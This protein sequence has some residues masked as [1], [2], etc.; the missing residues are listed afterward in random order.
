MHATIW[1]ASRRSPVA[2]MIGNQIIVTTGDPGNV[3]AT[4]TTWIGTVQGLPPVT[5]P[6]PGSWSGLSPLPVALG[7]VAGGVIGN[8]L[9]LV[10]EGNAATLAYDFSTHAW[11]PLG[12][13][14]A[15]PY[16]GNHQ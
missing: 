1:P 11:K 13:L 16:A 15:R 9:Y 10:G 2:Q 6:S 14:A 7:E 4:N 12:T 3:S 8:M 5:A